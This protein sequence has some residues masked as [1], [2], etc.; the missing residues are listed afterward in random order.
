MH[1]KE[2]VNIEE[3][4]IKACVQSAIEMI[5]TK[6]YFV[7][8]GISEDGKDIDIIIDDGKEYE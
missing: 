5:A 2:R 6:D 3:T 8:V 4:L 1:K 7:D